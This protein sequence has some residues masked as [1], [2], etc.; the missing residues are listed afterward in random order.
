MK[1][2]GLDLGTTMGW[3][4]TTNGSPMGHSVFSGTVSFKG[5]RYEGGGMRFLRFAQWLDKE[6]ARCNGLDAIYFEEVR[7]HVGTDAAHVYA[8]FLGNLT[9][10]C[11]EHSVPYLGIPVG[12]VK[13]HATGKG[14][15]SKA[16][17]IEA[18]KVTWPW[19]NFEDDNQADAMWVLDCGLEQARPGAGTQTQAAAQRPAPAG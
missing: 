3:A 6:N 4:F 9:R 17:M 11:E 13:K 2:L 18:A 19:V 15:A 8:G 14:N 1:A 12:T 7:R 5:G 16:R 10:W